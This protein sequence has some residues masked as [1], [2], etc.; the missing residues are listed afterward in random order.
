[1]TQIR[2]RIASIHI[3][4]DKVTKIGYLEHGVY[5]DAAPEEIPGI[6]GPP[7]VDFIDFALPDPSHFKTQ[8]ADQ[9]DPLGDE[10]PNI[11]RCDQGTRFGNL[12]AMASMTVEEIAS[13]RPACDC[14]ES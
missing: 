9:Q 8:S 11:H 4:G 2:A 3:A 6:L 5:R 10:K 13:T 7:A 1:M 14:H 12:M